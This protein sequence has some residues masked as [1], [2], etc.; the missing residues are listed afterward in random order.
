[1]E[2]RENEGSF[3][4]LLLLLLSRCIFK[5]LRSLVTSVTHPT[6]LVFFLSFF[7]CSIF[8]FSSL[9]FKLI[10]PFDDGVDALD[11]LF[12]LNVVEALV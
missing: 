11:S 12:H 7:L 8:F 5:R 10:R 6:R 4:L 9:L 1:M 2:K 3:F